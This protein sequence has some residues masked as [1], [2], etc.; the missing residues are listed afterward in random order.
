MSLGVF[1][2]VCVLGAYAR[3]RMR[4][5]RGGDGAALPHLSAPFKHHE[6]AVGDIVHRA[7]EAGEVRACVWDGS[8]LYA[9]VD[10]LAFR[11]A[12]TA[13][14]SSFARSGEFVGWPAADVASS[15]AWL[16]EADGCLTVLRF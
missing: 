16:A 4:G 8:A 7:D 11:R 14:A 3:V 5:D 2:C 10:K 1:W 6:V 12:V 9:I 15:A 13:F